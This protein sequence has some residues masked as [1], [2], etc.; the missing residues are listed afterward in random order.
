MKKFKLVKLLIVSVFMFGIMSKMT[1]VEAKTHHNPI[2][3]VHGFGGT[4]YNFHSI[5]NYLY[6][7]GWNRN[8]FYSINLNSKSGDN[9]VNGPQISKYVK[10]V[11]HETGANKVDLVGHSLGGKNIMYYIKNLDGGK[12][13]ANVVTLGGANGLT[14]NT[15]IPG[16]DSQHKILYT[17]IYSRT[18]GVVPNQLSYLIG[19]KNIILTKIDHISLLF[20]STVKQHIKYAL[21]GNGMNTN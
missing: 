17:S 9:K 3:F 10:Q 5:Q 18:D 12:N 2:V 4:Q 19:G 11:Q 20:N 7:Q 16:T 15:A 14:T 6:T 8:Q 21:E 13:V 1:S